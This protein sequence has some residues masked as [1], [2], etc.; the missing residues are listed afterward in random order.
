MNTNPA[1]LEE[2]SAASPKISSEPAGPPVTRIA[3]GL[4]FETRPIVPHDGAYCQDEPDR[5]DRQ[6]QPIPGVKSVQPILRKIVISAILTLI[7]HSPMTVPDGMARSDLLLT[8]VRAGSSGDHLLFRKAVEALIAEERAK[9]HDVLAE[10]LTEEL[11]KN[12]G[13]SHERVPK[14]LNGA[15]GDLCL[16]WIPRRTLNDL[17]LPEI[18][19]QACRELI[20]EHHRRD[21]LRSYGLEPRH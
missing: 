11:G 21:L 16:E 19:Q 5:T 7:I 1:T 10:R 2:R 3:S 8:L 6:L 20:E 17:V 18:V 9:K 4:A 15:V 14:L 13:L 12:G